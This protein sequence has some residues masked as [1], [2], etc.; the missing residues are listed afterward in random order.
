MNWAF[1]GTSATSLRTTPEGEQVTHSVWHHWIDSRTVSPETLTDEGDMFLQADG[2]R[3][4]ERGSAVD[5]RTGEVTEY[6]ESW[7]DVPAMA[8]ESGDEAGGE[9]RA[10][11]VLLL[12]DDEHRARGMVV[13]VGQFCQG[14]VRVG[15]RFALE[16]WEWKDGGEESA[17]R[18]KDQARARGWK[19]AVRVGDWWLPCGAALREDLLKVG[20]EVKHQDMVWKV[21]E[22]SHF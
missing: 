7:W 8:V 5:P 14:F 1:A 21:V 3:T 9:L 16:R 18:D 2:E 6:E 15:E 4:L 17:R 10:N 20:G 12:Q 13:R 22:L 19:R 11:V